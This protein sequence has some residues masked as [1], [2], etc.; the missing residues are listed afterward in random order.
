MKQMAFWKYQGSGN[1]FVMVDN[2]DLTFDKSVFAIS[3]LCDRRFGIGADGLICLE[4]SNEADFQMVYFN[5]DGNESTFCGNGGRCVVAFARQLA[6]IESKTI[7]KAKDGLHDAEI[8]GHEVRLKMTNVPE[9][10]IQ[11]DGFELFTGSPHF[12]KSVETVLGLNVKFLGSEIRNSEPYAKNGINVN[13]MEQKKDRILIRT[14]E[15]GVEDETYSCG[16]GVTASALVA[17]SLGMTSPIQVETP[18]G[19]LQVEFLKTD[20][21]SFTEIFLKGPAEMVFEG[22]VFV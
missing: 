21:H 16:T 5:S 22:K 10:K 18:G 20:Q 4:N 13:F 8:F 19:K 7:F 15:R 1:D 3:K 2:R 6:I 11:S 12:V 9:I 14:F 17:A